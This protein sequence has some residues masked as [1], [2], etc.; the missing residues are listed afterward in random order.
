[1]SY[2]FRALGKYFSIEG[3]ASRKELWMFFLFEILFGV[4]ACAIDICLGTDYAVP[5]DPNNPLGTITLLYFAFLFIPNQTLQIRRLH[6][7]NKS[8]FW[9][10]V[11]FIP[12]IG[13][14]PNCLVFFAESNRGPNKYGDVPENVRGYQPNVYVN[15]NMNQAH[16]GR[17]EARYEQYEEYA[18]S[19]QDYSPPR[20]GHRVHVN[21]RRP[22][23][24]SQDNYVY[25]ENTD[26]D[27]EEEPHESSEYDEPSVETSEAP[28]K[29]RSWL[30]TA[31]AVAITLGFILFMV[32]LVNNSQEQNAER[33]KEKVELL[34]SKKEEALI[35]DFLS[36]KNA[37][38]ASDKFHADT[39]L[40]R[41]SM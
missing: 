25:E 22:E 35:A 19:N 33:P 30:P 27:F 16:D 40:I 17:Y 34:D 15:V 20:E 8:G 2:F 12:I 10:I 3:R 6:D 38:Y 9:W 14:Y 18:S 13:L 5:N 32:Y 1:M 31:I 26:T 29:S 21:K 28:S 37:G 11:S 24:Q 39:P 23:P 7:V 36:D 41:I 4:G